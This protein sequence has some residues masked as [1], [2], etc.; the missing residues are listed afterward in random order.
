MK[1]KTIQNEIQFSGIGLHSGKNVNIT[2][3]GS[4]SGGVIFKRI[5]KNCEIKV[6]HSN[7][8][9]T[10]L[11]TSIGNGTEKIL[12]I[13]HLMAAIW[14]LD[15]DNLII[16]IDN[17]EVP[18][19]DGSADIFIK[20]IMDAKVIELDQDRKYLKILREIVVKESDKYIKISPSNTFSIDI[21]V[22]FNYGNIGVQNFFFEGNK[23]D[24]IKEIS[25]ARTFCNEKEVEYM[26]SIGLALGGSP[27]NAMVFDE[28]GLINENGFRFKNEVVKHK[29][30]D[31]VGDMYVSG[32]NILGKIKS[33]KG[34]HTLDNELLESVFNDENNYELGNLSHFLSEN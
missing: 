32:Y 13:E 12:T 27:D 31:C 33:Y 11:G 1:E 22:D 25:E 24:F 28:K 15:I 21:T 14:A 3:K 4:E 30:L 26:R 18:I 8:I 23:I 17:Q 2:L 16:E 6:S 5:D 29:L 34:G 20:K 19:L 9:D 7:V 10:K